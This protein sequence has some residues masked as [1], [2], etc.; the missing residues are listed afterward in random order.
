MSLDA[1]SFSATVSFSLTIEMII[2]KL[3]CLVPGHTVPSIYWTN[4]YE[5]NLL[6]L[7]FEFVKIKHVQVLELFFQ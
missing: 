1:I 2:C 5:H 4:L 6:E 3:S 7:F